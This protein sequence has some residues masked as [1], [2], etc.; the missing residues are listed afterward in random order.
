[1]RRPRSSR[2]WAGAVLRTKGHV[3]PQGSGCSRRQQDQQY[4]ATPLSTVTVVSRLYFTPQDSFNMSTH[5]LNPQQVYSARV[6]S[7][8]HKYC[9]G[10]SRATSPR[11]TP[12]A[13]DC[14]PP[15]E[16]SGS[17][18][19][20]QPHA[21]GWFCCCCF[22]AA[23]VSSPLLCQQLPAIPLRSQGCKQQCVICECVGAAH[24]P[25]ELSVFSRKRAF[26]Q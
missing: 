21:H 1:M 18:P 15:A 2:T 4:L 20:V 7:R 11:L 10:R 24:T 22:W 6:P 14:I 25:L 23:S 26:H 17:T 19:L 8:G 9:A 13:H 12:M 16:R 5:Y 3:S